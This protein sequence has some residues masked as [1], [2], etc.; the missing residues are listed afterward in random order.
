MRER[1]LVALCVLTVAAY[2]WLLS[3]A[4]EP[5]WTA[6]AAVT[7]GVAWT[8]GKEVFSSQEIARRNPEIVW[9]VHDE[10]KSAEAVLTLVGGF[11]QPPALIVSLEE[12]D[13]YSIDGSRI[14]I[15]SSIAAQPGQV[16]KA[17]VKAW[18]YQGG[19]PAVTS[20]LL[21]LE[22]VSDLLSAI[23]RNEPVMGNP[24]TGGLDRLALEDHW[25]DFAASYESAHDR[26]WSTAELR[27]LK[28]D[29]PRLSPLAFRPLLGSLLWRSYEEIPPL[30]RFAFIRSWVSELRRSPSQRASPPAESLEEWRDWLRSEFLALAAGVGSVAT[31]AE[32][33]GLATDAALEINGAAVI[34]DAP[35]ARSILAATEIRETSAIFQGEDDIWIL[36][37]GR[38][39]SRRGW[40]KIGRE[41]WNQLRPKRVLWATCRSPSIGEMLRLSREA[42]TLV[43][44]SV[45]DPGDREEAVRGY[46]RGGLR[47]M[48]RAGSGIEFLQM[49]RSA[50]EL[51]L[52]LGRLRPQD[53]LGDFLK[54][55]SGAG[56]SVFGFENARWDDDLQAHRIVGAIEAFEWVRGA[57]RM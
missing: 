2:A 11:R 33:A 30:R 26:A 34:T 28:G 6:P 19:V 43:Y 50:V 18:F 39:T 25:L 15:A 20:S 57:K 40:V 41:S 31:L 10:L 32:R 54:L 47:E 21:R 56:G 27:S 22:V 29:S 46:L 35:L 12:S 14:E 16:A 52:R 53:R 55:E 3:R 9:R 48:A 51:A 37:R 42:Q 49:R 7:S 36:S 45:C 4:L 38:M 13:R 24:W 1:W 5:Q 8:E 23:A 17:M 44:A